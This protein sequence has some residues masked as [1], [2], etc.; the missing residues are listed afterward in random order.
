MGQVQKYCSNITW[1]NELGCV[2]SYIL[3]DAVIDI[4]IYIYSARKKEWNSAIYSNM[5]RP[6]GHYVK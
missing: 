6:R 5:D 4:Y 1:F 3:L 2:T